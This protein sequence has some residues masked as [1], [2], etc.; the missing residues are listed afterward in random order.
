MAPARTA[1][2][3]SGRLSPLTS[4][5]VHVGRL[6]ETNG[7]CW[8]A[9]PQPGDAWRRCPAWLSTRQG[10]ERQSCRASR[11]PKKFF[12]PGARGRPRAS[13]DGRLA[14]PS[15]PPRRPDGGVQGG[16][17]RVRSTAVARWPVGGGGRGAGA[18]GAPGRGGWPGQP[19]G[20]AGRRGGGAGRVAGAAG[21]PRTRGEVAGNG[22]AVGVV[23]PLTAPEGGRRPAGAGRWH[24]RRRTSAVAPAP[25]RSGPLGDP[26][27]AER[28]RERK[29]TGRVALRAI[30][31]VPQVDRPHPRRVDARPCP[32]FDTGPDAGYRRRRVRSPA[33]RPVARGAIG[34]C[35]GGPGWDRTSDRRIMSPLL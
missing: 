24:A 16:C 10:P 5:F 11:P 27:P 4:T 2:I 29:V 15:P 18:A 35:R 6:L 19:G 7:A 34:H 21:R 20:A 14:V 25:R 31:P 12:G 1:S 33:A 9:G 17:W 23:G 26:S 8:S 22:R 13:P 30:R 28:L 32:P 3:G